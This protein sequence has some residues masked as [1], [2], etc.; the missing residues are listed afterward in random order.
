MSR[1]HDHSHYLCTTLLGKDIIGPFYFDVPFHISFS[2][3]GVVSFTRCV[4]P[5]IYRNILRMLFKLMK[6]TKQ[7]GAGKGI[8]DAAFAVRAFNVEVALIWSVAPLPC[9]QCVACFQGGCCPHCVACSQ[10]R[11]CAR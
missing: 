3:Y 7:L 10:G 1:K 9:P 5:Y 2:F 6:F 8:I 11:W 4:P